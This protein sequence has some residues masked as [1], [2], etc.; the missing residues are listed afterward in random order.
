VCSRRATVEIRLLIFYS[1]PHDSVTWELGSRIVG[2]GDPRSAVTCVLTRS[3]EALTPG[4]PGPPAQL[5]ELLTA[6]GVAHLQPRP[7]GRGYG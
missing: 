1:E 5:T 7:G 4:D 2:L 3:P 6:D